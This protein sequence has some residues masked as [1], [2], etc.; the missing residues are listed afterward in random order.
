LSTNVDNFLNFLV[1]I[2]AE[3]H[4]LIVLD[5]SKNDVTSLSF[6]LFNQIN[7]LDDFDDDEKM[8]ELKE[9]LEKNLKETDQDQSK[10]KDMYE[11]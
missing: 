1:N 8:S 5:S 9:K 4:V 10:Y 3:N 11:D 2:S 7:T 6:T